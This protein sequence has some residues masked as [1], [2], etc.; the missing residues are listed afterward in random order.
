MAHTGYYNVQL[1]RGAAKVLSVWPS[2][3]SYDVGAVWT[4][5]G[6]TYRLSPGRYTWF[7]WPGRGSKA[8]HAFGPLLGSS[9]FVVTG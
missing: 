9:S 1:W 8:K 4:Y 2:V 6:R 3:T 5:S 7:V